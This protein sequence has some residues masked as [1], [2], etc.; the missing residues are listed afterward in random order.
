MYIVF[1]NYILPAVFITD[2][3][4]IGLAG[5]RR[6]WHEFNLSAKWTYVSIISYNFY[7]IPWNIKWLLLKHFTW[8]Y[9]TNYDLLF[10]YF[11]IKLL[12]PGMCEYEFMKPKRVKYIS[13]MQEMKLKRE[14]E[15]R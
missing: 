13:M 11:Q 5:G 1:Y 14:R 8:I 6:P 9:C 2:E 7:H 3:A 4:L 10:E 12:F 15:V